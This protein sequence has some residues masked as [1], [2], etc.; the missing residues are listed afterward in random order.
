MS[1][2]YVNGDPIMR[3]LSYLS[4]VLATRLLKVQSKTMLQRNSIVFSENLRF[5]LSF[6]DG[7][8][9]VYRRPGYGE[10]QVCVREC[11]LS[12]GSVSVVDLN[13]SV[14]FFFPDIFLYIVL[15]ILCS[16]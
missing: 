8:V 1:L 10:N 5:N 12:G 13:T 9:R 15:H 14:D 3:K 2:D 6:V 11:H 7:R 4:I 16:L